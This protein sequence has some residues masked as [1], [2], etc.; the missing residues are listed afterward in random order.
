MWVG[1][2]DQIV[3][4]GLVEERGDE[5]CWH[6]IEGKRG[7]RGGCGGDGVQVGLKGRCHCCCALGDRDASGCGNSH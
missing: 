7:E 3:D 6:C 2:A 1:V 5:V 4:A